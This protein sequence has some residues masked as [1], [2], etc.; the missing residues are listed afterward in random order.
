MRVDIDKKLYGKT[1]IVGPK[2]IMNSLNKKI[3]YNKELSI[4]LENN[5]NNQNSFVVITTNL[6]NG[7]VKPVKTNNLY[8]EYFPISGIMTEIS[9]YLFNDE[10]KE[11]IDK[12]KVYFDKYTKDLSNMNLD[13]VIK[14][15]KK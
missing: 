4:F 10:L 3:Y 12:L 6:F 7:H 11:V 13:D 5:I 15:V 1:I 2:E 8:Y 9:C 14:K